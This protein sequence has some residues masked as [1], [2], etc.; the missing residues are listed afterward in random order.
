MFNLRLT[1]PNCFFPVEVINAH[2][3]YL[4]IGVVGGYLQVVLNLGWQSKTAFLSPPGQRLDDDVWHRVV[5][6]RQ[7]STVDVN[8]DGSSHPNFSSSVPGDYKELDTDGLYYL[9][10]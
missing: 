7:G 1:W 4:G 10:I 5:L 3:D 9:G 2:S 6:T 8:V